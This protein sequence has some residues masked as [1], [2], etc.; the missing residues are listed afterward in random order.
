MEWYRRISSNGPARQSPRG[1]GYAPV[2]IEIIELACL[3]H[4]LQYPYA[5]REWSRSSQ[6]SDIS[7]VQDGV[8]FGVRHRL[9]IPEYAVQRVLVDVVNSDKPSHV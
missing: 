4:A 1:V 2:I 5:E 8:N 7:A 6:C 3:H 9:I